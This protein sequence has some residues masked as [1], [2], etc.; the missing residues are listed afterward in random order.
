MQ[1]RQKLILNVA[2]VVTALLAAPW[3][4]ERYEG[5]QAEREEE[6]LKGL[7]IPSFQI[8]NASRTEVIDLLMAKLQ[9]AGYADLPVRVFREGR[10][11]PEFH[12]IEGRRPPLPGQTINL[13][14]GS[15]PLGELLKY[16]GAA[17][18]STCEVKGRGLVLVLAPG[19]TQ[20]FRHESLKLDP[21][22][23]DGLSDRALANWAKDQG[24]TPYQGMTVAF[25]RR[26]SEVEIYGP[27]SE[28]E[29][30]EASVGNEP[31][32]SRWKQI[33]STLVSWRM[34]LLGW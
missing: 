15:I 14:L 22:F 32:H 27:E 19:T 11:V 20:H 23:F 9:I 31:R 12:A 5:W 18:G 17:T 8:F 33:E 3:V 25:R 6:N 2:L 21:G 10:T 30:L 29:I 34:R 28:I 13:A 26:E 16:I 1:P 7:T 4:I 24:M